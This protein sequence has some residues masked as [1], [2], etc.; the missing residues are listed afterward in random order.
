VKNKNAEKILKIFLSI[1]TLSF[2]LSGN[3]YS[4]LIKTEELNK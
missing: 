2:L 4:E 3:V 1:I